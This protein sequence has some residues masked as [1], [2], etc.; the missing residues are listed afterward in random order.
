MRSTKLKEMYIVRYADDF[1]IFC[2]TKSDAEKTKIAVTQWL[3]QRL[4]LEVSQEKTRIINVKRRYS[5]FLGFKIKVY[6]KGNKEVVKSHICDKQLTRKRQALCE[7]AKNVAKPRPGKNE[8][9][10]IHLY[11]SM[12]MGMQNYYQIATNVNLDCGKLNR[13]VMTIF[14]NRLNSQNGSRLQ[15]SGRKLTEFERKRFGDSGQKRWV[16]GS[17]EPIHPIGYVQCKNPMCK[18][19]SINCYTA[20]GRKEIHNNL[21]VNMNLLLQLMRQPLYNNS[22]EYADNRIS[23]FSAQWG[24]CAVTGREFETIGD[25]HCHH[26]V[27]RKHGGMDNYNNLTLVLEPIHKLIHATKPETIEF[28]K[29]VCNLDRVQI[30]KLNKLRLMAN[31]EKIA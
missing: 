18:K 24:K 25:I 7:Q 11:N 29:K 28:Y 8:C 16:A 23:L 14:T 26:T 1:R 22:A 4:R 10:E 19:R 13:A 27:P 3:A 20:E 21:R 5:E 17:D 12:V 31:L 6:P 30:A 9:D 2:R 15:K